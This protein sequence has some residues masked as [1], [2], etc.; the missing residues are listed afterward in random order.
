VTAVSTTL[1]TVPVICAPLARCNVEPLRQCHPPS[2][3]PAT[4]HPLLPTPCAAPSAGRLH[5][6]RQRPHQALERVGGN[7]AFRGVRGGPHA[8][9]KAQHPPACA[10][11]KREKAVLCSLCTPRMREGSGQPWMAPG[12]TPDRVMRKEGGSPCAHTACSYCWS[13]LPTEHSTPPPKGHHG[14]AEGGRGAGGDGHH[15]VRQLQA[16]GELLLLAVQPADGRPLAALAGQAGVALGVHDLRACRSTMDSMKCDSCRPVVS[17]CCS[18]PAD[19][20][21]LA[22]LAGQAGVALGVH[23]LRTRGSTWPTDVQWERSQICFVTN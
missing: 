13:V 4:P 1:I 19:G 8:E 16:G 6:Q 3:E 22:A 12:A 17:S 10:G 11:N 14:R 21:P 20:R 23:D 18:Q 2:K 7:A 5:D 9:L 15:E